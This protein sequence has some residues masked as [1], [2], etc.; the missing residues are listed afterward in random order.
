MADQPAAA[1]G[2]DG[3]TTVQFSIEKI[4][5]KDLSLENP[6]APKSFQITKPRR[7]K[8]VCAAAASRSTPTSTSAS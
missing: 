8:S 7:S 1:P 4:Y 5:V 6:G 3:F 2:G